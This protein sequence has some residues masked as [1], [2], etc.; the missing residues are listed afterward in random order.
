MTSAFSVQ[1][2]TAYRQQYPALAN[3]TY[4]NYGGQ[5]PM[6]QQ[7]IA[8]LYDTQLQIQERGPFSNG[9]N[10]WLQQESAH[11]RSAIASE[12]GTTPDAITLTENVT[13]GCNIALWSLDWREGDHL[14]LTDCEHPGIIAAANELRR[15]FGIKVSTCPVKATLNEGNPVEAIAQHLLPTTRMLVV[16]HILWNTGQVLPLADIVALCHQ[17][18][19]A[20]GPIRVLVDAAQSVGVLPLNLDQLGADFYA[21]TGH[22]WWCGAAGAGG[23]YVHPDHRDRFH[24]TFIGWR[25]I[26]MDAAGVPT[27]WLPNG[28]RYE[29]A[30]SDYPIYSALRLAIA[31]HHQQGTT[32]ERYHQICRNS[33]YLWEQ[34]QGLPGVVCLRSA[35]PEAG[36]VSFQLVDAPTGAHRKLVNALE[37]RHFLLRTLADPDCIRACVHYFTTPED[38][39]RLIG[40][41][42]SLL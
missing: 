12:L 14:L 33:A 5:G 3:K 42:R 19:S 35:P 41:L 27:G 2:L 11:T 23:L 10:A 38:I 26:T 20:V 25:G 17:Y 24:P 31:I 6:A 32:T 34:L 22:K 29:V 40:E 28:Q 13:M 4:F 37:E 36:L 16:S 15:R 18:P 39:D 7:A 30:T 21:F 9:T 8:A 1:S